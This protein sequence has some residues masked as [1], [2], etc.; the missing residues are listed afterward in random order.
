MSAEVM[1]CGRCNR[2]LKSESSRKI[3][4]GPVCA[5]KSAAE[6]EAA[7]KLEASESKPE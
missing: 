1:F 3:G 4:Y 7:E 2:Q 6:K 5:A